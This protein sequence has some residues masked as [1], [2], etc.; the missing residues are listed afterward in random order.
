MVQGD[1]AVISIW[2]DRDLQ[3][4]LEDCFLRQSFP[5][6]TFSSQRFQEESNL[7]LSSLSLSLEI[8]CIFLPHWHTPSKICHKLWPNWCVSSPGNMSKCWSNLPRDSG[9]VVTAVWI[10]TP[11]DTGWIL[12]RHSGKNWWQVWKAAKASYQHHWDLPAKVRKTYT[13]D[14]L[15]RSL[16]PYP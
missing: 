5:L 7:K 16:R 12:C 3:T 4:F 9:K 8:R 10:Q 6:S 14:L 15:L 2:L 1:Y 11:V 13:M